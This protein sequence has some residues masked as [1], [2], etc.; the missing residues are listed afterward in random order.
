M[1]AHPENP[2][3]RIRSAAQRR[4]EIQREAAAMGI[5][6]AYISRLVDTFYTRVRDDGRLGPIFDGVIGNNWPAHLEKLKRFWSSVALST[7]QYSGRPVPAHLQLGGVRRE[8][9]ALW[10]GLFEQTVSETAPSPEAAT[11][12]IERANRIARSL[13]MAMFGDLESALLPA[14]GNTQRAHK[15]SRHVVLNVPDFGGN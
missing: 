14:S 4:E 11:F 7:G 6:E 1:T 3:M 8:D 9:F 2:A 13:Q 15:H 5:D 10:L 12:F